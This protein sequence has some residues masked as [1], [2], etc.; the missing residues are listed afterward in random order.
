MEHLKIKADLAGN[1]AVAMTTEVRLG[2]AVLHHTWR[3]K[4]YRHFH[5]NGERC[6][7]P[8][9]INGRCS[10]RH[11]SVLMSEDVW[12]NKVVTA[13]LN[14]YLDAT[15]KTGLASPAWYVG[16][17]APTQTDGAVTTGTTAFTSAAGA[18]T[19]NDT[20]SYILIKGAG[21]AGADYNNTVTYSSGTAL[22][23]ASNAGTTVS[24]AGYAVAP[25]AADTMASHAPWT[26]SAVYSNANRVTW[27]AGTISAGSVDNSASPAS[28]SINASGGLYGAFLADNNTKSGSTGNL[29]G[30]GV[31]AAHRDVLSGD[32]FNVTMTCSLT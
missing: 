21:A 7:V 24:S 14:K 4:H 13:G 2:G 26:E 28:F 20:G 9:G 22:T 29:L 8:D 18:F 30:G 15:L 3:C 27:T 12:T 10:K 17:I 16:L 25:R 5:D 1:A 6:D 11:A 23:L 32:T 19:S 31:F